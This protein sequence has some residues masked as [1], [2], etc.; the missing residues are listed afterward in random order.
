MP[1]CDDYNNGECLGVEN[2][3]NGD[4]ASEVVGVSGKFDFSAAKKSYFH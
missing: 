2:G 4:Y 1:L 3:Q